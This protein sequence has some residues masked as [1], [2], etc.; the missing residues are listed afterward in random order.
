MPEQ[1]RV[2]RTPAI[3]PG[4]SSLTELPDGTVLK[5]VVRD[6]SSHGVGI[7]G[8]TTSLSLGSAVIVGLVCTESQRTVR[9]EYRGEVKHVDDAGEFFGVE[10]TSRPQ[11]VG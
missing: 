5:G 3:P 4:I 10:L 2:R 8:L 1:R 11:V 7:S 9:V 6:I